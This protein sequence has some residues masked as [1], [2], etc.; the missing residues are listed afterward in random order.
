MEKYSIVHMI[1]LIHNKAY[2]KE[3]MNLKVNDQ[4]HTIEKSKKIK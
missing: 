2:I 1:I 4:N 3:F